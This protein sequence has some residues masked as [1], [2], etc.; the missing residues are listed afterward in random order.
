MASTVPFQRFLDEHR[1]AVLGFLRAMVGRDDADDL[2][3]ETF[4]A[5]LRRYESL[6]GANPR[7]WILTI[8]RRK[9][10]DHHRALVRRREADAEV[11]EVAAPAAPERDD[12]LWRAVAELPERQ[13]AAVA[14]RFACDLRYREIAEAMDS[15]EVA[16]RRN[17]HEGLRKLRGV[18]GG[19]E[20]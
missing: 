16:A 14:L 4:M 8:A 2:F 19:G 1:A 17:V 18:I 10:I 12:E 20:R 7:A 13:R 15:T 11:P 6:D 9:A 3:Q 5:A